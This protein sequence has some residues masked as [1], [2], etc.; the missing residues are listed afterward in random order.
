MKG[1]KRVRKWD[2]PIGSVTMAVESLQK[3]WFQGLLQKSCQDKLSINFFVK[4]YNEKNMIKN[5]GDKFVSPNIMNKSCKYTKNKKL[6]EHFFFQK[7]KSLDFLRWLV[8][9]HVNIH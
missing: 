5:G 7:R 1:K 2:K 9:S 6:Q 8:S 4:K 3:I